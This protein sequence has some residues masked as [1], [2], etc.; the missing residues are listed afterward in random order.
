MSATLPGFSSLHLS[1]E[2]LLGL[3]V[4]Q[5]GLLFITSLVLP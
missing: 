4:E 1:N 2:G 3:L 5:A